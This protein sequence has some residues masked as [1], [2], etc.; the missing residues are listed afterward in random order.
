MSIFLEKCAAYLKEKGSSVIRISEIHNNSEPETYE[1][2]PENPLQNVYSV[3][4]T[5]TMTAIGLLYDKGLVSVDDKITDIFA[6][7]LPVSMDERWRD[8][9]VEMALVHSLGLPGGFLDIDVNPYR[10]F[11]NDFL[12]YMF[13]YPLE[14]DPGTQ[15]KYSDG[16][17]Y[18][19]ARIAEKKCGMPLEDFMRK[20]LFSAM[21]IGE[22][23]W[24]H[25]PQGHAM[26]AT[27]LYIH[28]SDA[29]KLGALYLDKG[30]YNGNRLLS[31]EWAMLAMDKEY[32]LGWDEDRVI[33][34]KGG[35]CGQKLIICPSQNRCVMME[36]FGGN[37]GYL[38]EFI[39]QY[40]D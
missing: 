25:C 19:L 30:V 26:G 35:M 11:G 29:V 1:D 40:N 15:S 36:S 6:D 18:L 23:A 14:Y 34:A 8:C 27:G 16:A 3:A 28:S 10:K 4:K 7:E 12:K 33:C 17:F 37:T 39:K 20:E 2:H 38:E 21:D 31:E 13:E 5:F 24:S 32:A 22:I 9:T